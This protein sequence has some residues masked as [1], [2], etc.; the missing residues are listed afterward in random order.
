MTV[1][2]LALASCTTFSSSVSEDLRPSSNPVIAE[3]V[4]R[5]DRFA[6][7]AR[8]QHPRILA[9]YGGEYS[10]PKLERMVAKV[11]GGLT[12]DPDHPKQTY[13][14][15]ILNSPNV[16]AFALPAARASRLARRSGRARRTAPQS[17][18]S[19]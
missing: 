6:T 1:L 13:Q 9:T 16:N 18:R 14:I 7:L 3:T 5:N 12:L 17:R 15:T 19:G 8:E 2:P 10:D 11:V 4:A